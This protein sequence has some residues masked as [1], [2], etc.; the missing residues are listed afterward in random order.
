MTNQFRKTSIPLIAARRRTVPLKLVSCK[1]FS[2]G[3]KIDWI[4]RIYMIGNSNWLL[5]L[6]LLIM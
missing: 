2:D 1:K 6:I 3:A 4:N 5:L